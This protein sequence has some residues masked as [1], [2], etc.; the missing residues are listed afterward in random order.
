M[1]RNIDPEKVR[2]N[3]MPTDDFYS[4]TIIFEK[5][6]V[7]S[8]PTDDFY[9]NLSSLN[10]FLQITDTENFASVPNDW[11]IVVTDIQGSTKLIESGRY[12]EVNL[13]GAASIVAALNVAKTLEIPYVFGGDGASILI[14]PSLLEKIKLPL[15]STQYLAKTQF[16]IDLR[17][18]IVPVI[19]VVK[20]G[21]EVKIAKLKIS[22]NCN[23]GIFIGGGLN[24]ATDL[25]KDSISTSKYA[26]HATSATEADFSGLECRWQ[27]IPGKHQEIVSLL[28]LAMTHNR[29]KDARIYREVIE[30]I[31]EIYGKGENLNPIVSRNLKLS[32]NNKNLTA[33]TK[34][35]APQKDWLG[36]QLYLTKIKFE[37]LLGL[38]FMKFKAQIADMNW[39]HY[40]RIVMESTDFQKFDDMLRMI[41]SGDA[42]QREQLVNYLE[43][44]FKAGDLVYGMHTSDRALMTCL[45]FERNGRQ[46][47]F[48]DGANGGYALAAKPLKQQM[49]RKAA[50][51]RTYAELAKRRNSFEVRS[52]E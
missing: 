42:I 44:R 19:D 17:V 39:G 49:Q 38:I 14:P 10:H 47:H 4:N 50:N 26:L 40:K 23:Q 35:R 3:S 32:F 33:E 7:N 1:T 34:L 37:N 6:C 30:K 52:E 21:Y 41:I 18:G 20:A 15:L 12:K 25:V 28:I 51:W 43:G 8:M 46:V 48:L 16:G 22:E 27:S 9:S 24:H 29:E 45:V 31:Q 13:L 2:V 11:H 5:I 36:Q